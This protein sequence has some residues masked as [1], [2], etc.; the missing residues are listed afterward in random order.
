MM[1]GWLIGAA[2]LLAGCIEPQLTLCGDGTACPVGSVCDTAHH[3]CAGPDQLAACTGVAEGGACHAGSIDGRCFD[4]VCLPP[5]CGNRVVEP[6]EQ[7]DDGN[8]QS[9]DGCSADCRSNE[10]C[11]NGVVDETVGE[12]CDD[13]NLVSHDGCNSRCA[14]ET[15]VWHYAPALMYALGNATA[16]DVGRDRFV[17]AMQHTVWEWDSTAW[18]VM[19][20]VP[21][22]VDAWTSAVYDANRGHIVL[23][24][25]RGTSV[26]I[27][28]GDGTQWTEVPDGPTPAPTSITVAIYDAAERAIRWIGGNQLGELAIAGDA[29]T[30]TPLGVLP[31]SMSSGTPHAAY[32]AVHDQIVVVDTDDHGTW[33]WDAATGWHD[34]AAGPGGAGGHPLVFDADRGQV[35]DIGGAI[36]ARTASP[37]VLA[38]SGTTWTDT[39]VRIPA[40]VNARVWYDPTRH[41]VGIAGG[42]LPG[43]PITTELTDVLELTG[44][45]VTPHPV[46]WPTNPNQLTVDVGRDQIVLLDGL[47]GTFAWDG[48]WHLVASTPIANDATLVYDPRRGAMLA[49]DA[50]NIYQLGA[51]WQ[52]LTSAGIGT[53]AI[54]YDY[55][56]RAVAAVSSSA[57]IEMPSSS[58]TF[59]P[60]A[61]GFSAY[62][63]GYDLSTNEI[64][65]IGPNGLA[66]LV[67][68]A[69]EPSLSPSGSFLIVSALSIA[70][71]VLV[72]E[73]SFTGPGQMWVRHGATFSRLDEVPFGDVA[74]GAAER[75][76]GRLV[77]E[78]NDQPGVLFAERQL[79][80]ALPDETCVPGEDA[81]H[82]GLA[83]CDDPDCWATCWPGCPLA[84]SCP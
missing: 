11:G 74:V 36:D 77:L 14:T 33:E 54:T 15:A 66:D 19:A 29:A 28:D 84:T 48:T 82:D 31:F 45:T 68:T 47:Q 46:V 37:A 52:L 70:S 16:F 8:H 64:V 35:L 26:V 32:D 39:G 44:T 73:T 61:A 17:M 13:G 42:E 71:I 3:S 63:S 65:T 72:P 1:R 76:R 23:I 69:W 56:H 2:L 34:F 78:M 12:Q 25:R 20:A 57:T 59:Q 50:G 67:G 62:Q 30:W 40:R 21:P 60:V 4:G 18:S 7:C 79:T 22:A 51:D 81:D 10:T 9:G 80:S 27:A 55:A 58:T 53:T 5:G 41:A 24:G 38:W 83:G 49:F 75:S 43:V 6:G